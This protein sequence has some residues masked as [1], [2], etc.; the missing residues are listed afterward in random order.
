MSSSIVEISR[1]DLEKLN[2]PSEASIVNT[3]HLC[4]YNW[5]N[6][7]VPTI[8][9]PG[10]PP[11]W[12]PFRGQRQLKKDSGLVYI[13]QNADRHPSSPLEPLFRALYL[14]NAQF[15]IASVDVVTD[16]NNIRKLL[17]FVNP[18]SARNGLESFAIKVELSKGTALFCRQEAASRE[19]IMPHQFRGY[20]HEY[21]KAYTKAGISDSSGHHRIVSYRFGDLN[22]I[23]RHETDGYIETEKSNEQ[24]PDNDNLA[25]LLDSLSLSSSTEP[26]RTTMPNDSKLVIEKEGSII[27]LD[28]T[29]EIKTRVSHKPIA[30]HEVA[31]QL[32]VSQTPNLVRAYHTRGKFQEAEVEEV[33][34]T[35]KRWEKDN[36]KHLRTLSGLISEIIKRVQGCGGRAMLR[37]DATRDKLT[38][39][40]MDGGGKM[41]PE[42]LYAKWVEMEPSG[43]ADGPKAAPQ[44]QKAGKAAT[45]TV[46]NLSDDSVNV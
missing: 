2:I 35:V 39:S 5:K 17:G 45:V 30:F 44:Q 40:R 42:D 22:F 6:A 1:R 7:S 12:K 29:L 43:L 31:P 41:L 28:S 33:S 9:V 38:I 32:W 4:S 37:Y 15:N 8:A 27:P 26:T 24:K 46:L 36:Q 19:F 13:D 14:T 10:I 23:V 11:L 20:G 18:D 21:E 25:S 3:Q 34:A 16:R